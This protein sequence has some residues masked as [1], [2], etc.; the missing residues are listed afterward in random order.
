MN[1][2][3][4]ILSAIERGDPRAG[5]QLLPLIYD[6]LRKLAAQKLAQEAPGQTLQ[7]TA[8]VH[9]AY[10][11]LLPR[12]GDEAAAGKHW[13]NSRHFFAA[14]AEAMRRILLDRARD[15]RRLKRGGGWRRLN[16]EHIDLAVNEPSAD[17]LLLDAALQKLA[18]EDAVCADLVKLRFFAGLTLEDA[19]RALGISRR[20]A[21][22]Y[23]AFARSWLY[24][25]LRREEE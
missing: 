15:K 6:E 1:E 13:D 14:A 22:R 4:H 11:R 21:D 3:T 12:A 18:A 8:L 5:E 24:D 23:W 19:A 2:V 9:E 7:A 25:E 16:L 10:L 20:S 17:V